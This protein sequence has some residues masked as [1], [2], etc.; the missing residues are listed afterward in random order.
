MAD[1]GYSAGII[2]GTTGQADDWAPGVAGSAGLSLGL[3]TGAQGTTPIASNG[4]G[5]PIVAVW[6][7]LN[8]PFKAPMSPWSIALLVGVVLVSII[9]W[10]LILYHIR[11]A[12]E[13]I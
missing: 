9:A 10:N 8:T 12:A 5:N 1:I 2:P 13:E 11:I 3:G 7:W 4:G 6:N